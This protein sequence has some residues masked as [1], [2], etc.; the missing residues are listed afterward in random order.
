M[1]KITSLTQNL[2]LDKTII[3][4]KVLRRTFTFDLQPHPHIE[5]R[6]NFDLHQQQYRDRISFPHYYN[7]GR[8]LHYLENKLCGH[9]KSLVL[10]IKEVIQPQVP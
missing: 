6:Y 1:I 2:Q 7:R 5:V 4:A 10:L 8:I 3:L 9:F